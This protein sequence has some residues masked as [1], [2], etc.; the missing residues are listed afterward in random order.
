LNCKNLEGGTLDQACFGRRQGGEAGN[1]RGNHST[2]VPC[3]GEREGIRPGDARR[4]AAA[5]CRDRTFLPIH[6]YS[7]DEGDRGRTN[8]R[9]KRHQPTIR[10]PRRV[11]VPGTPSSRKPTETPNKFTVVRRSILNSTPSGGLSG[12]R[13]GKKILEE[14]RRKNEIFPTRKDWIPAGLVIGCPHSHSAHHFSAS[15]L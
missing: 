9:N 2:A 7:P 3:L 5:G 1:K 8:Q 15:W 6:T 10:Q 13:C 14:Q 12:F 4:K 11:A